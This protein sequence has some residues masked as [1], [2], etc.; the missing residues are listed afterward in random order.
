[1]VVLVALVSLLLG[2][3]QGWGQEQGVTDTEVK[4]GTSA[5]L[6]GP[7]AVWGN[8]MARIGSSTS[9]RGD[10]GQLLVNIHLAT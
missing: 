8:R 2:A 9:K 4:I 6:T 5:G 3:G 1:M 7:I 10:R